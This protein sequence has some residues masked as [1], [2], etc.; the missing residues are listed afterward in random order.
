MKRWIPMIAAACM[1]AGCVQKVEEKEQKFVAGSLPLPE[2]AP[3]GRYRLELNLEGRRDLVAGSPGRL[4]FSLTNTDTQPVRIPEWYAD[5]PINIQ[6]FCQPWF[7]GMEDPHEDLWVPIE[8]DWQQD[9]TDE[10]KKAVAPRY[11]DPDAPDFRF[12]L[13]LSPG[14]KVF[15][16]RS[17]R[18]VK[19]MKVADDMERRFFVKAR[20]NLKSVE[21]ESPVFVVTVHSPAA[22]EA[23]QKSKKR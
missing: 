15:I 1:L 10:E 18:I 3:V 4:H 20:L 12:P 5:E 6:L 19:A 11:A 14:N 2:Y 9:L 22:E 23:L 16:N 17:L 21:V 13:E 8:Y 7:E